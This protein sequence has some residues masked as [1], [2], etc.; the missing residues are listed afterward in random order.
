V[1]AEPINPVD[2]VINTFMAEK[3]HVQ[4]PES[5]ALLSRAVDVG[6]WTSDLLLEV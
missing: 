6:R 2:P 4:R 1:T 5:E 3:Y